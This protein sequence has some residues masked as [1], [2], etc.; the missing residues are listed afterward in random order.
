MKALIIEDD[1]GV[2]ESV[3]LCLQLRIDGIN[4]TI[5]AEGLKAVEMVK[6]EQIDIVILDI[7]LPD[8]DGFEVLK[9]IRRF[10]KVPVIIVSVRKS[11]KDRV[12]GLELG[13]DDYV[14]KPFSPADLSARVRAL[15]RRTQL[16]I[17]SEESKPVILGGTGDIITN[18]R[19]KIGERVVELS[20]YESKLLR[21]LMRN[22]GKTVSVKE[23]MD[24]IWEHNYADSQL[25]ELYI[26]KLHEKLND[27]PPKIIVYQ[28][29][30]G[31]RFYNPEK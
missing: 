12:S 10:S 21:L 24:E 28:G 23:I 2:A 1:L 25:V 27:N 16:D 31:Y 26:N 29:I 6:S 18:T 7:N 20:P 13:A 17:T 30:S 19:I 22:E 8:I 9:R 5:A 14:T 3:S 11:E 4:A 15:L